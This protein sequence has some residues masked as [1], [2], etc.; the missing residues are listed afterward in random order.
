MRKV[1]FILGMLEDQDI[2]W[3]T[4]VG[5]PHRMQGGDVLIRQ[6]EY[7]EFLYFV[8][9]G[10]LSVD[11][12]PNAVGDGIRVAVLGPGDIVGEMSY[13]DSRPPDATVSAIE[14]SKLLAIPRNTLTLKLDQDVGFAA[15]FFRALGGLTAH[16]IRVLNNQL[17]SKHGAGD[18]EDEEIDPS[19]LETSAIAAKRFEHLLRAFE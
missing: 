12:A 17:A 5:S 9:S 7:V 3:F 18:E 4:Q 13:L 1:L 6:G 8:L 15:R 16:R 19:L 14:E 11:V 2:D 10:R